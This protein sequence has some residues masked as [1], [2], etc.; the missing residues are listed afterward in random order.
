MR[1]GRVRPGRDMLDGLAKGW[2]AV[3]SMRPGRVRPGRRGAR[4]FGCWGQRSRFNEAGARTPRKPPRSPRPS[5][6]RG[7]RFNEAGARTPRKAN[8]DFRELLAILGALQ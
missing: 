1:P 3:A 5:H 4:R 7:R 2:A 8:V 6:C